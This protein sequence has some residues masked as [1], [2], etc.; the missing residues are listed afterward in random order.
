MDETG[1]AE[2]VGVFPPELSKV[3]IT[4]RG[5]E[6]VGSTGRKTLAAILECV[7]VVECW[8]PAPEKQQALTCLQLWLSARADA[9]RQQG[10]RFF[11]VTTERTAPSSDI[12]FAQAR[13][14][15]CLTLWSEQRWLFHSQLNHKSQTSFTSRLASSTQHLSR[16]APRS[17]EPHAYIC[18]DQKAQHRRK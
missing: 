2:S 6:N 16:T 7:I 5:R 12:P 17:T 13:L 18:T 11:L 4:C 9:F 14:P 15:S 10:D 8:F 3:A 1:L